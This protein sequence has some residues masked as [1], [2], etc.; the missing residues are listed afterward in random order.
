[1]SGRVVRDARD[2]DRPL[3]SLKG[4]RKESQRN[5]KGIQNGSNAKDR[6]DRTKRYTGSAAGAPRAM[7]SEERIER[8]L[9]S[10]GRALAE[11]F[12][13]AV[14]PSPEP[15]ALQPLEVAIHVL[16]S[17]LAEVKR[18]SQEQ[19]LEIQAKNREVLEQKSRALRELSTPVIAVWEGILA[20]PLVGTVDVQR[21]QALLDA[22]LGRVVSARARYVIID[23]TGATKLDALTAQ[24][25]VRTGHAV[26]LLGANCFLTGVSPEIATVLVD[27]GIDLDQVRSTRHL[28]EALKV[29]FSEMKKS[30][31]AVPRMGQEK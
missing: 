18:R 7:N 9:Q 21:S 29:A 23:L 10:I 4:V 26:R 8:L 24:Y 30:G 6:K 14:E 16:I 31:A 2:E 20:L 22:V 11:D 17:E 19:L 12:S 5:P 1:V 27:L 15:D 25:L 28:G 13:V 3:R